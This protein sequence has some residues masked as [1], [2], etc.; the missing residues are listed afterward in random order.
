MKSM[1]EAML[2]SAMLCFSKSSRNTQIRSSVMQPHLITRNCGTVSQR[3]SHRVHILRPQGWCWDWDHKMVADIQHDE[4]PVAWRG[5]TIQF[6]MIWSRKGPWESSE[7]GTV[8][9]SEGQFDFL[10]ERLIPWVL[11]GSEL[12]TNMK[13]VSD[14]EE[15][16]I[17]LIHANNASLMKNDKQKQSTLRL[18]AKHLLVYPSSLKESLMIQWPINMLQSL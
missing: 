5:L 13:A 15:R 1:F 3:S 8:H 16:E 9:L 18:V 7:G 4:N 12:V 6:C 10:E 2:H 17:A 11:M 14:L